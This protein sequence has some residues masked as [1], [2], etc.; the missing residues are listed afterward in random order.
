M[1]ICAI[2]GSLNAL[3]ELLK[4]FNEMIEGKE[5]DEEKNKC[6][7]EVKKV[8]NIQSN[9]GNTVLH[10]SIHNEY[11]TMTEKLHRIGW[12]DE[13]IVNAKNKTAKDIDNDIKD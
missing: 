3:F 10:E 4:Y 8:F 13:S 12:I 9:I 5:N 1:H 11:Q 6:R 7:E 2:N